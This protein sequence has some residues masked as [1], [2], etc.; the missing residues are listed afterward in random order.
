M[1]IGIKRFLVVIPE[2]MHQA[3]PCGSFQL[4]SPPAPSIM[5][6]MRCSSTCTWFV[7]WWALA[8]K[9]ALLSHWYL[10][11]H[12]SLSVASLLPQVSS[13]LCCSYTAL[14]GNLSTAI[15]NVYWPGLMRSLL[16]K[17]LSDQ[18][19]GEKHE[20]FVVIKH[21]GYQSVFLKLWNLF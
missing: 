8:L 11:G 17:F 16:W 12:G 20:G 6:S 13:S 14:M 21:E 7:T 9:P 1:G 10:K 4:L 18:D 3:G 19:E 15:F 2:H 5:D